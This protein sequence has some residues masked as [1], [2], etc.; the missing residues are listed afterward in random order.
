MTK[1]M[2]TKALF[3]RILAFVAVAAAVAAV[4]MLSLSALSVQAQ[5]NPSATRQ[6]SPATVAPGGT[7]TVTITASGFTFARLVETLPP[8]FEYLSSTPEVLQDSERLTFALL[9][10]DNRITYTVRAPQTAGV[11]T[12]SG[13]LLREDQSNVNVGG[14]LSVT[15]RAT[16]E[17]TMEPTAEP[18]MEPMAEPTV[19]PTPRPTA[20]PTPRPTATPTP[21]P[22]AT[23]TPIPIVPPVVLEEGGPPG[24]VS[25]LI[26]LGLIAAVVAGGFA[27]GMR[28]RSGRPLFGRRRGEGTGS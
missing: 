8:G 12:F 14:D 5:Q 13:F 6:I 21:R 18:T 10:S 23:P 24:W 4:G 3:R 27:I 26:V 2:E 22:T 17:P 16:P 19:T 28:Q 11:Y 20:T 25:V 15:V 1:A 9:S 7:L